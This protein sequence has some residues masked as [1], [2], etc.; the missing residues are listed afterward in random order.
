M[1]IRNIHTDKPTGVVGFLPMESGDGGKNF[2]A[3]QT[4]DQ[5]IKE[6]LV[7]APGIIQLLS[8]KDNS[9]IATAKDEGRT[10]EERFDA[11]KKIE[12]EVARNEI[13][14]SLAMN[15][16]VSWVIRCDAAQ[17]ITDETNQEKAFCCIVTDTG[18]LIEENLHYHTHES[19]YVA[20]RYKTVDDIKNL[21]IRDNVL[22]RIVACW[23][24]G[25][26]MRF[27]FNSFEP[28]YNLASE[29]VKKELVNSIVYNDKLDL[30]FRI[31][32]ISGMITDLGERDTILTN[33]IDQLLGMIKAMES[34]KNT[35]ATE[36]IIDAIE[37]VTDTTTRDNYLLQIAQFEVFKSIDQVEEICKLFEKLC[38]LAGSDDTRFDIIVH[39]VGQIDFSQVNILE[40]QFIKVLQEKLKNLQEKHKDETLQKSCGI[41]LDHIN[42]KKNGK[43]QFKTLK[44]AKN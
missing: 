42:N 13:L 7:E 31:Q 32:V 43:V 16:K 15:S 14:F 33:I 2:P 8:K 5:A 3:P 6:E 41:V 17:L 10:G 30:D 22:K 21:K 12:N 44:S 19:C 9:L 34:T 24:E 26:S 27:D 35:K 28:L 4:G 39:I 40:N 37:G 18:L 29:V 20:W 36:M 38:S 25:D 1:N 11:A 23:P